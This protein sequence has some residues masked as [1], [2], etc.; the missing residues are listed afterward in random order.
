MT[1]F[2]YWV[3]GLTID[4]DTP[5]PE[6]SRLENPPAEMPVQVRVRLATPGASTPEFSGLLQRTTLVDG[7][8]W[9]NSAKVEQGYL[10]RFIGMADFV[11]DSGGDQITCC[12]AEK[13][14]SI[15]TIRHLVL[16]QVFPMVLN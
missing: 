15:D 14:I 9:L 3:Y 7:T 10:L 12:R 2:R 8:P 4:S 13:G 6:L 11:V 5:F 16:D 1:M